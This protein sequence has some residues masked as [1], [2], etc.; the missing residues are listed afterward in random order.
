MCVVQFD[1]PHRSGSCFLLTLW[2]RVHRVKRCSCKLSILDIQ[3]REW[4][5][6]EPQLCFTP[7]LSIIPPQL[8]AFARVFWVTRPVVKF[9]SV[10][11]ASE[12]GG[13]AGGARNERLWCLKYSGEKDLSSPPAEPIRIKTRDRPLPTNT[14]ESSPVNVAWLSSWHS[15]HYDTRHTGH[16]QTLRV[17]Y[18]SRHHADSITRAGSWS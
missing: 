8:A 2:F 17:Q 1:S 5:L 3:Q 13:P 16:L 4:N 15:G 11:L 18:C 14:A 9:I 7:R 10:V 6:L 12:K